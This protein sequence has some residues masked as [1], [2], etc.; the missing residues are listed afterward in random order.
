MKLG[1]VSW[2]L[3][4][5]LAQQA[6]ETKEKPWRSRENMRHGYMKWTYSMAFKI[7]AADQKHIEAAFGQL[8]AQ[9]SKL[10]GR[11]GKGGL[12]R[13]RLKLCG[14]RAAHVGMSGYR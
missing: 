1:R 2:L 4:S 9:R 8:T 3:G 14:C 12:G 13:D 7:K 11:A 5:S 10:E 6:P